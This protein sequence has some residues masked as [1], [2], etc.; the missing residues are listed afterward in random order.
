MTEEMLCTVWEDYP[1]PQH[2]DR[3]D[4]LEALDQIDPLTYNADEREVF[5]DWFRSIPEDVKDDVALNMPHKVM[6]AEIITCAKAKTAYN[7]TIARNAECKHL[8]R[9]IWALEKT[10]DELRRTVRVMAMRIN[11]L[12]EARNHDGDA[13]DCIRVGSKD[14]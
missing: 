9:E 8:K 13:D 6:V 7:K 4:L 5:G 10:C 14:A 11:E 12:K 3:D 2:M 1:R